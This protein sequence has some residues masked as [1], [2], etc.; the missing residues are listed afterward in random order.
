MALYDFD[1]SNEGE[2]EIKEGESLTVLE[3]TDPDWTKVG[4][5][6]G[7]EGYVPRNYIDFQ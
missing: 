1:P 7:T 4:R 5:S 6:D 3:E 2:V